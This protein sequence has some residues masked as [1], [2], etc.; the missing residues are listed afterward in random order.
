MAV[1][2]AAWCSLVIGVLMLAQWSFL[3]AAGEVPELQNESVRV[4]FHLAAEAATAAALIT[5]AVALLRGRAHAR[6]L[7]LVAN[8]MLIYTVVV[9]PG[10][11]AQKGQ[12]PPV[13]MFAVLLAL[14]LISVARL[15]RANMT[16]G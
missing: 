15:A 14:A 7:G 1:K 9:S 5:A 13:A 2:F 8:G 4:A 10:Y 3:L 6:K 12:W 16:S 11:F